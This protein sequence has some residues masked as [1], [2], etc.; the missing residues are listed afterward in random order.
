MSVGTAD[1]L[2]LALRLASLKHQLRHGH[3]IPLVIDDCLIQLDDQR[4]VAALQLLS[5]LS[6][7][8]QVILFTHHRH[9]LDLADD[10]LH[11]GEFHIHRL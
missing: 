4:A 9:L 8:T 2:Y 7:T 1:A 5:D 11:S 10:Q 3:P 6:E